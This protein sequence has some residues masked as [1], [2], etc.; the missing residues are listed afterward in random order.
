VKTPSSGRHELQPFEAFNLFAVESLLVL[1]AGSDQPTALLPGSTWCGTDKPLLEAAADARDHVM[2][3]FAPDNGSAALLLV[4]DGN[5]DSERADQVSK[6]LLE[7]H[8]RRVYCT[9]RAALIAQY[10][11]LFVDAISSLPV[12]PT[13]IVPGKLFLGSAAASNEMALEQ[14]KITHVVSIVERSLDAPYGREHLLCQIPDDDAADIK[15]VFAATLPFISNALEARGRVLVHCAR[16]ASRSVSVVVAHLLATHPR[17][18][19]LEALDMV[20]SQRGCAQPNA[21]F[22]MSLE[23]FEATLRTVSDKEPS[24]AKKPRVELT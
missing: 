10:S 15:P 16:G 2:N 24:L 3:K 12:Y 18:K 6:W 5:G 22:L 4:G 11:F 21:G 13:E 14:L 19:L 17:L 1:D 8:C 23:S 7:T 20:K 9:F